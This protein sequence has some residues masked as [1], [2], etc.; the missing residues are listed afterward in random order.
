MPKRTNSPRA[1]N[2]FL[3]KLSGGTRTSLGRTNT[4]VAEV[5]AAP[6][7]FSALLACLAEADDEATDASD[8]RHAQATAVRRMRA[9]DAVEKISRQRP[10]WLA[11]HKLEFLG[12]A[13]G[14]DQIEVRWHMAQIL[15]RLP[16][17]PRE[18]TVAIDILFDYLNDRSSIVKTHAMQALADFAATDPALKSKI[19]PL[20][21][22]LTQIGTAAMRARGR[23]LLAHLN[24]PAPNRYDIHRSKSPKS[25]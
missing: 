16:L 25:P 23:K 4:V 19:L 9:A 17:T 22:E 7:K 13:G 11:P 20:L 24:R 14:T 10:E 2:P 18:R 15:P 3:A 5:L 1:T 8:S 6:K 21:E 12:L